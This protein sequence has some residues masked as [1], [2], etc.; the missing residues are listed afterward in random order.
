VILLNKL[1]LTALRDLQKNSKLTQR[2]FS[3][4]YD[5]SLG[6]TNQIFKTLINEQY[7]KA[8]RTS[9]TV[10]EKGYDLLREYRVD[11]AVIMAA[12]FGSRFVPLSYELPKGLLEVF[13]ERMVERQ[14]RQ[15][16][17]ASVTD[18]TIVVGYLKEKFEYLIDKYGVKLVY[19]PDY[20]VKNNLS[21]L[22]HVR[23]LLKNTYILSSDN[24]MTENLYNTYEFD[25]W[26][27]AVKAEGDT[28][29]W[30]ITVDKTDRI[31]KIEVGG[32]D[33]WFMYGPV[34]FSKGFSDAI[35]PLIEQTYHQ[36]GSNNFFWED[37]LREHI[38]T[39][40]MYINKQ[41]DNVVYEF[42]NLEELRAFDPTY[43]ERS[44]SRT[45]SLIA[46][47]FGVG[48]DAITGIKPLKLGMTNKSF[49]FE[50]NGRKYICRI[51]GEGTEKL[52]DRQGEY[53][54]FQAVIPLKIT[55]NVVYMD[56]DTGVKIAE[57]ES[58]ARIADK[59]SAEDLKKCMDIVKRVHKSGL[60]V[61]HSF[62]LEE[63]IVF[64]E[65][66]CR[67]LDA[68]LY[69]DYSL[70][71][72]RMSE[73]LSILKGMDIPRE[74]CH[75]DLNSDNFLFLPNGDIKLIDWEYSAMCDPVIDISMFAIYSYFEHE[76]LEEL[77]GYY[78]ENGPSYEE[79]LRIYIYAALGGFL[80]ALWAEYKQALGVTFGDYT[81]KMYRYA[82]TYYKK[83][84]ELIKEKGDHES[85]KRA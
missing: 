76:R 52:I 51:P 48:E 24:Y 54:S 65:G 78:F 67:P 4:T 61:P 68:I 17:E 79:R 50:V 19:N 15:L 34:Y 9:Y 46:S 10:T 2:D 42:E 81:L 11:N 14:I 39:L 5:V 40:Q 21:T 49:Y 22:Y 77:M 57:F 63:K 8:D 58:N 18:I 45:M 13:G 6:K 27:S 23:H 20:A 69:E 59:N 85:G 7:I 41:R 25:S 80:W 43:K 33:Q 70:V 1:S 66:L 53:R 29:E 38:D 84:M 62:E 28:A 35:V 30:C 12:G 37:V 75:I 56:P 74:L 32:R 55:E 16:L 73:L 71:R 26:Y 83:S 31:R 82:K 3:N 44:N 60:S 36:P 47:I 72:V 64:Y